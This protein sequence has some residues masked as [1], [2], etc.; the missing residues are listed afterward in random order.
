MRAGKDPA[1]TCVQW[2][3]CFQISCPSKMPVMSS[4]DNHSTAES[5]A[6]LFDLKYLYRLKNGCKKDVIDWCMKMN[7]IAKEYV[8]PTCEEKMVL[9][10]RS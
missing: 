2:E 4:R 7:L 10:E 9:T 3:L 1:Q 8:C 5:Q 6:G